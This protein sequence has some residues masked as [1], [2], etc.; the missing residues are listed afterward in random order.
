MC[1]MSC[2][3][4]HSQFPR[5]QKQLGEHFGGAFTKDR[6]F[7]M[8][9]KDE[10]FGQFMQFPLTR[11]ELGSPALWAGRKSSACRRQAYLVLAWGHGYQ[12][13]ESCRL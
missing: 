9:V 1:N 13:Y 10:M 3:Q 2:G 12:T 4:A 11:N 5:G 7:I 8:G 6:L